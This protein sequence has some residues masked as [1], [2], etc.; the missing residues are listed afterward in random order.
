MVTAEQN[1]LGQFIPL[2]YHYQMLQDDA[3]M[4]GFKSALSELTPEGGT[5]VD[6]GGGTGVLS[7]FAAH[8]AAKVWCIE[9]N[10]Q[11]AQAARTFLSSNG[12]SEKVEVV[13][14]DAGQWVPPQPVDIVVCEMLHSALLREKQLEVIDS[15]KRNYVRDVSATLPKFIPEATI[16]AAQP[17]QQKYDF[18]GYIAP[19]P[20]FYQPTLPQQ[21]TKE[22]GDP[23]VYSMFQ[24]KQ[25]FANNF[26]CSISVT[27]TQAGTWN[28]LRFVTK[29]ILAILVEKHAT[30]DWHNF[31]LI[32]PL[33]RPIE[34]Q[35]GMQHSVSFSY[36]GGDPIEVLL[37]SLR[38]A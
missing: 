10:P 22:L 17:V 26:E 11:M 8:K 31:Y 34:V 32:V 13:H 9:H 16:L 38:I 5:V 23:V 3:R 29:N 25:S 6:L 12:C 7:F 30:I 14:A 18:H 1:Y 35:P 15:F 28:A 37:E 33:P 2:H 27:F 21:D 36:K 19:V 24:Y 20:M 4:G